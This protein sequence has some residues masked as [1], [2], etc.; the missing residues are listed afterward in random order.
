MNGGPSAPTA[1]DYANSAAH[2]AEDRVKALEAQVRRLALLIVRYHVD[3]AWTHDDIVA[4]HEIK[5][6][7]ASRG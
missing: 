6:F 7:N 3:E 2:N 1:A 4:L 5:V